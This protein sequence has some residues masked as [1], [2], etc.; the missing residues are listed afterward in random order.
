MGYVPARPLLH[1][2]RGILV[3]RGWTVREV[4]WQ[5]PADPATDWEAWVMDQARSAL[6]GV[7]ARHVLLVGKSLGACAAPL[8]AE[9]GLPAIWLT[10]LLGR[11]GV[12]AALRRSQA[13]TLLV[14]GTADRSWDGEL[15]RSLAHPYV[16][17][18]GA[19]HGLETD[20]PVESV[21]MLKQVTAAMSRFVQEL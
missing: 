8:A 10:P 12:V 6:D 14:G 13:P 16:E 21:E 4:W 20:D 17:I 2:A 7:Q 19:H 15:V 11:E 3:R 18:P 9:R 5:P 1:F